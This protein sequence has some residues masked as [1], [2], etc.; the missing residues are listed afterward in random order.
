MKRHNNLFQDIISIE[1]LELADINARKGKLHQTCIKKHDKKRKE[2]I[3]ILHHQL[4]NKTYTT[5]EY[6]T[7]TIREPKERL[8]FRLPYIDRVVHHAI[9]QITKPIFISTFTFDTYSSIEGRGVHL[10]SQKV[11]TAIRNS[12]GGVLFII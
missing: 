6:T 9:L 5:S 2:N 10:A 4:K 8:I 1:N 11:K 3:N 12:G 7:F